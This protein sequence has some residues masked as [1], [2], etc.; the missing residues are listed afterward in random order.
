MC[1]NIFY[2]CN[3]FIINKKGC[4]FIFKRINVILVL[5]I[6]LIL[7]TYNTNVFANSKNYVTAGVSRTLEKLLSTYPIEQANISNKEYLENLDYIEEESSSNLFDKYTNILYIG[8]SRTVGLESVIENTRNIKF[9]CKI[10]QGYDW[11]INQNIEQYITNDTLVLINLG[12]NDLYNID[13]YINYLQSFNND[14]FYYLTVG[15]VSETKEQAFG[16]SVKNKD[17]QEFNDKI[18]DN[19]KTIDI[20]NYLNSNGFETKDGIHYTDQT[21]LNIY[22]YLENYNL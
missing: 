1:Y 3:Q 14:N 2:K 4:D 6:C 18:K 5:F 12:V 13:K 11:L 19:F 22:D 21:Y 15:P 17:I 16:Y 8:D 20:N 7:S 10:G 9:I